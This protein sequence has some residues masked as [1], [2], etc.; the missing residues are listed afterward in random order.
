MGGVVKIPLK[1]PL[2][3]QR[4]GML[5]LLYSPP[6]ALRSPFFLGE[7]FPKTPKKAKDGGSALLMKALNLAVVLV[8]ALPFKPGPGIHHVKKTK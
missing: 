6:S 3:G 5:S 7:L 2:A 4:R 1:L 8:L